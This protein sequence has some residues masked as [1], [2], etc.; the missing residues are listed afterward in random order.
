[1]LFVVVVSA[2]VISGNIAQLV[3]QPSDPPR[4]KSWSFLTDLRR[5]CF[6]DVWKVALMEEQG[7]GQ[8]PQTW[9][10]NRA[11]E[12]SRLHQYFKTD[13]LHLS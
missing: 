12:G 9:K 10:Q 5:I 1:M 8:R 2:V 3:Q 11:Q 4:R 13:E 6:E 7:G